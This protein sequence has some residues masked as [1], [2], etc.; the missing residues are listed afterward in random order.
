MK[1][2]RG[3]FIHE[4]VTDA[5][6]T[7]S[8]IPTWLAKACGLQITVPSFTVSLTTA[9]GNKMAIDGITSTYF[10]PVLPFRVIY[11]IVA[12]CAQEILVSYKD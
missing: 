9:D 3:T 6:C 10:K 12:P 4:S 8:V 2:E 5:G 1:S 11:F 7:A